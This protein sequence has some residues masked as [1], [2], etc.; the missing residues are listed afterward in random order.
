MA[1]MR[2]TVIIVATKIINFFKKNKIVKITLDDSY[3]VW[4][5]EWK[6]KK[7]TSIKEIVEIIAKE[8]GVKVPKGKVLSSSFKPDEGYE[9]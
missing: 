3:S 9:L 1:Q 4:R 5:F 2:I 7:D 8:F 6:F